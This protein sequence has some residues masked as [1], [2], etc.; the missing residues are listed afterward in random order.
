M[1][2][3]HMRIEEQALE[4]VGALAEIA[5]AGGGGRER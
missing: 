3:L 4:L 5:P 2:Y 1:N